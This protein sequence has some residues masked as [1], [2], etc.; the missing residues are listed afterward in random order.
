MEQTR[1]QI[2]EM[3]VA[4]AR[5]AQMEPLWPHLLAEMEEGIQIRQDKLD[6]DRQK[7]GIHESL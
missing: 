5:Y 1:Q 6:A 4:H 7:Q 3:L 2:T